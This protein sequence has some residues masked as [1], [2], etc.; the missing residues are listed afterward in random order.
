VSIETAGDLDGLRAAGRV[1]TRALEAMAAAVRPGI[2]TAGLDAVAEAVL[3][4]HG[5]RSAP[6]LAYGFPGA[7][8]ISVNDE[9]V[10][11]VPGPRRIQAGDLVT[12][13]VTVELDGYY[14]DAA[15]TIAVGDAP[16][17][18][19]RL[20]ECAREA[21]EAGAAVARDGALLSEVG[22]AV[23][24]AVEGRGF[25]VLRELCGHG[26]GRAIHEAPS[27][28]NYGDPEAARPLRS[29]TVIALEPIIATTTRRVRTGADGW[30]LSSA[31]GGLTAHYENTVVITREAPLVVTAA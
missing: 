16:E 24:S 31:D 13:D 30:T 19:I 28:P 25:R 10:H 23:E 27:V 22:A 5:A 2:T 4:E 7:T 11:G 15:R 29:G 21:W 20:V 9:A 17:A 26:I 18:A 3:A 6:R 8:C 12:L 1:V 14:A